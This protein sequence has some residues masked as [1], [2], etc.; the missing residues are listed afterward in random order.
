MK[1][2]LFPFLFA[3]AFFVIVP[4][5]KAAPFIIVT[6]TGAVGDGITDDTEAIQEAIN[7]A[8]GGRVFI[9]KGTYAISSLIISD[10]TT[11][12]GSSAVFKSVMSDEQMLYV[13]GNNI[14]IAGITLDGNDQVPN[15]IEIGS[16]ARNISLLN[17]TIKNISQS[18]Q[19][20]TETPIGIKIGGESN[21][22]TIDSVKIKNISGKYELPTYKKS[23]GILFTP[24]FTGQ[25]PNKNVTIKNCLFDEIGPR[26]DSDGILVQGYKNSIGITITNNIFRNIH[27][28]AI[29]VKSPGVVIRKNTI[30][31]TFK[32]NNPSPVAKLDKFD[33]NTAI[34]VY[35][36]Q[37]VIEENIISGI[38]SYYTGIEI[39]TSNNAIIRNN[40]I[41]NGANSNY[42]GS[43]LIR[44]NA[45]ADSLENII[46]TGNTLKN[47]TNGILINS[48]M[49]N[50]EENNNTFINCT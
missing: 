15:G 38:G 37:V 8:Q 26:G 32:G 28:R 11:L 22:I 14:T 10:N 4:Q 13:A 44:L 12:S 9:P 23:V 20:Q 21:N 35:A 1:K 5:V 50:F 41:S 2:I 6:Q 29:T 46:I 7:Q 27:D 31:N 47:A 33:M 3:V 39:T 49:E 42:T 43:D 40:I 36:G 48:G 34:L 30:E 24:L 17:I 16:G 19:S 18:S 25:A 45:S